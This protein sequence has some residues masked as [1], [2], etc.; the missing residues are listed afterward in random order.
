MQIA[1]PSSH[2]LPHIKNGNFIQRRALPEKPATPALPAPQADQACSRRVLQSSQIPL[3][4][5]CWS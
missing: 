5:S 4:H 3:L 2:A 1:C